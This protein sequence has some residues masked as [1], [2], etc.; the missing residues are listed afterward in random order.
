M[1]SSSLPTATAVPVCEGEGK[2]E[3]TVLLSREPVAL[4]ERDEAQ[5]VK[6][7]RE[8]APPL[9]LRPH[10][11]VRRTTKLLKTINWTNDR[12]E[13]S[14]EKRVEEQTGHLFVVF[15]ICETSSGKK[16]SCS[17]SDKEQASLHLHEGAPLGLCGMENFCQFMEDAFVLQKPGFSCSLPEFLESS[18]SS[19]SLTIS[20]DN[21]VNGYLAVRFQVQVDL[22]LFH[23]PSE[24]EVTRMVMEKKVGALQAHVT[25]EA[26]ALREEVSSLREM[27]QQLEAQLQRERAAA[28][29]ELSSLR[30]KVQ[31]FHQLSVLVFGF[32]NYPSSQEYANR[33][34]ELKNIKI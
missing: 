3:P 19:M 21:G 1:A 33:L 26:R 27:V 7:E 16:F 9:L 15:I 22:A 32:A 6:H 24:V 2:S 4:D 30:G 34:A 29:T 13:L 8:E 5:E 31:E 25:E 17:I 23:N 28:S 10:E 14:I 11:Q 18:V 20:Y 12:Y